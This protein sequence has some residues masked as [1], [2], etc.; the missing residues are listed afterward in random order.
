[1]ALI[2]DYGISICCWDIVV[3]R[4]RCSFQLLKVHGA[5]TER[6]QE[7]GGRPAEVR[8]HDPKKGAFQNKIV[9]LQQK[10]S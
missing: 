9:G 2:W 10:M 5:N 4:L 3:L 7:L 1:M 8:Q 6:C